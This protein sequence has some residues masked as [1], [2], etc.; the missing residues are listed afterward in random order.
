MSKLGWSRKD[1]SHGNWDESGALL[2][3]TGMDTQGGAALSCQHGRLNAE[4]P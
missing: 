2:V 1:P 3:H 4:R